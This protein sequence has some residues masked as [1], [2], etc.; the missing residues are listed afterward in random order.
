[1]QDWQVHSIH[2]A[3]T[4]SH[5]STI[6]SYNPTRNSHQSI[7]KPTHPHTHIYIH[8]YIYTYTHIYA[9]THTYMYQYIY[10]Y[11]YTYIYA[12]I[13]VC[14]YIYNYMCVCALR[15]IQM[16]DGR[17]WDVSINVRTVYKTQ[18]GLLSE[19]YTCARGLRVHA[20]YCL[21]IMN[22]TQLQTA[23]SRLSK[24]SFLQT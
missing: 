10:I 9:C 16:H 2:A 3:E 6:L 19:A 8:Q 7:Y 11:M 1:M 12:Y 20:S 13:Y 21:V 18:C 14:I 24:R 5:R 23:D 15:Y 22:R 4:L 17:Y